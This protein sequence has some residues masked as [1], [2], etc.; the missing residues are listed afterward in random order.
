MHNQE[1]DPVND[2]VQ[3]W[4]KSVE[5]R[6]VTNVVPGQVMNFMGERTPPVADGSSGDSS[7]SCGHPPQER[8]RS[9]TRRRV[10]GLRFQSRSQHSSA[11]PIS[12]IFRTSTHGMV[13][14]GKLTLRETQSIGDFPSPWIVLSRSRTDIGN[15]G[16]RVAPRVHHRLPHI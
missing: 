6:A 2:V 10:H 9:N 7:P 15:G 13:A 12:P 11:T 5:G 4:P 16:T 14:S 3:F 8:R 1:F